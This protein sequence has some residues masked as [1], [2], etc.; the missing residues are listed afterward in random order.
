MQLSS[1]EK[2]FSWFFA[3]YLKSTSN[4]KNFEKKMTFI[5]DVFL[6]FW[7]AKDVV[8]IMS[9]KSCFRKPFHSQHGKGYQRLLKSAQQHFYHILASL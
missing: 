1:K 6:K 3:R 7:T 5:A 2:T 4:F 8:K 9:K